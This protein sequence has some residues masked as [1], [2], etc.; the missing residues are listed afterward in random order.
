MASIEGLKRRLQEYRPHV[1]S[2]FIVYL[3]PRTSPVQEVD[4]QFE[5][6]QVTS[7]SDPLFPLVCEPWQ[8]RLAGESLDRG[9]WRILVALVDGR[10]VG[11]IW[12][13]FVSERRWFS[14]IPRV[15]LAERETFMFDLFVEREYR[16][17]N[18]GMTM[19]DYFFKL[20]D[21][22]LDNIDYVYGFI[23]YENA[24][25]ILWHYSIGFNIAQTINYLAVGPRIKWR[26]PFSDNPRFGPLSRRGR[27]SDPSK[28]LFGTSLFPQT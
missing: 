7:S 9:D 5:I 21:P 6:V 10:P 2:A 22:E 11:R 19:A 27:Y 14:G 26:I 24:P 23:S 16:R 1:Q 12:E 25:S 4:E 15:R 28:Q 8:R 18:I 20:Y 17:S 3:T 13:T